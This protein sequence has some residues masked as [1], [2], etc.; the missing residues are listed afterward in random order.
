MTLYLS[1]LQLNRTFGLFACLF[2]LREERKDILSREAYFRDFFSGFLMLFACH[3]CCI[4]LVIWI[5]LDKEKS[6]IPSQ[7]QNLNTIYGFQIKSGY[8]IIIFSLIFHH[9]SLQLTFK[10]FSEWNSFTNQLLNI[11]CLST[12][13]N[14]IRYLFGFL[15]AENKHRNS[16]IN[17]FIKHRQTLWPLSMASSLTSSNDGFISA[18]H[19]HTD[20]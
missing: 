4:T 2:D 11:S 8:I 5:N 10:L 20:S 12:F 13:H 14:A 15:M 17:I 18:I 7:S 9:F 6:S 1:H 3:Y 19:I 16:Q